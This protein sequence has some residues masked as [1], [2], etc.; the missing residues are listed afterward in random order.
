MCFYVS[1]TIADVY[2]RASVDFNPI[3]RK[4]ISF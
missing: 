2:Q 3:V 1:W 4:L